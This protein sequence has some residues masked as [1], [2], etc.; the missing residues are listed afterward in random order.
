MV[1]ADAENT[2]FRPAIGARSGVF[3]REIGPSIPISAV[4][5]AY[6]TPGALGQIGAPTLPV[7]QT[8][9][10]FAQA[11]M[12]GGVEARHSTGELNCTVLA[13]SADRH[14]LFVSKGR[15]GI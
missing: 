10:G 3:V 5:L 8:R 15:G 12:F 11:D 1:I 6:G 7:L 2:V 14:F 13:A 9:F 4:V